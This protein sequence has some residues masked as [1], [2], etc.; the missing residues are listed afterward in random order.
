VTYCFS[1]HLPI[2][3]Y[4]VQVYSVGLDVYDDEPHVDERLVKNPNVF[5]LPH[6]GTATYETQK[7]MEELVLENLRLGVTEGRLLTPI[8]EQ[9]S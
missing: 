4:G 1:E 8:A 6:I 7:E 2:L 3:T 9:S 5:I